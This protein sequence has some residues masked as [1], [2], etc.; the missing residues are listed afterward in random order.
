MIRRI[1]RREEQISRTACDDGIDE[2]ADE[3]I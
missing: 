1:R 2:A 3:T